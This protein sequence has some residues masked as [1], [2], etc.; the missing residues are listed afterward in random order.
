MSTHVERVVEESTELTKRSI[1]ILKF[2]GTDACQ[3]LPAHHRMLLRQQADVMAKYADIL[4]LR[5]AFFKLEE[6]AR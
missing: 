4:T 6:N 1:A 2:M 3:E 5:L